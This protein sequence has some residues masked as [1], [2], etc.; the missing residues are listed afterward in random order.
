MHQLLDDHTTE[1]TPSTS[2]ES[3]RP[4]SVHR[5]LDVR[6]LPLVDEL[7]CVSPRAPRPSRIKPPRC[8]RQQSTT[9]EQ[10]LRRDFHPPDL[11]FCTLED[12]LEEPT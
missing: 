1:G 9:L 3:E 2:T 4:A 12:S 11:A 8:S 7:I 10:R 6:R 5:S